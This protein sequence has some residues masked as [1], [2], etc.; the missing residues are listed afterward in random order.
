MAN[1]R[2]PIEKDVAHQPLRLSKKN[3]DEAEWVTMDDPYTVDFKNDCP[4][5]GG[6]EYPV[7]SSGPTP[8]GPIRADA[9]TRTYHYV[10]KKARASQAA[11]D[12]DVEILP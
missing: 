1:V 11:G 6:P 4:F 7:N 10:V 12:P 5:V 9:E 2:I 3:K 8:S